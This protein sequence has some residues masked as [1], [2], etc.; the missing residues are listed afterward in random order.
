[1]SQPAH[2]HGPCD[3]SCL[4][5]FEGRPGQRI[6]VNVRSIRAV[7]NPRRSQLPYGP[8]DLWL[9]HRPGQK[10][11]RLYRSARPRRHTFRVP[12]VRAGRYAIAIFDGSEGGSHYTWT[13]FR[14]RRA[15]AR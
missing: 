10:A 5:A 9:A 12:D 4:S 13:Y 3:P 11:R 2:A 1:M 14:V 7:L 8:R 6:E 15:A